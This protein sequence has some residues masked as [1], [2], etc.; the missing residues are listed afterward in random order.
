MQPNR[1]RTLEVQRF[2]VYS[3]ELNGM[4]GQFTQLTNYKQNAEWI[5]S[6]DS[7]GK[8]T[9]C[10]KRPPPGPGPQPTGSECIAR[11][12]A[13]VRRDTCVFTVFRAALYGSTLSRQA[14]VNPR[15]QGPLE[16][17]F[18]EQQNMG[19]PYNTT[20]TLVRAR[21]ENATLS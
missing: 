14:H 12:P 10:S 20:C 16:V 19:D 21:M 18:F 5:W 7:S 17:T 3:V 6:E 2:D 8:I 11:D 13:A 4:G 1:D 9:G 15:R